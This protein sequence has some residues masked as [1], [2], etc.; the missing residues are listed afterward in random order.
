MKRERVLVIDDDPQLQR[1]LRA[2]LLAR[3]FTVQ[4]AGRGED[5]ILATAEFDPD[6]ILLAL[7]LPGITGVETCRRLREW[8]R[9]PIIALNSGGKDASTVEA[10]DAGADDCVATPFYLAELLARM[11]AIQRRFRDWRGAGRNTSP[12]TFGN[13]VVDLVKRQ[14]HLDG[15]LLHFTPTEYELLHVLVSYAGRIVTH[16]ELLTRVWGPSAA[17]DTQYLHVYISQLRRK[18]EADPDA[19][20]HFRTE[21]GV[22][23]EFLAGDGGDSVAAS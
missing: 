8:T 15:R 17:T 3:E 5:G 1:L 7:S 13:L 16:R 14:V 2:Q 12:L 11:R 19:P 18:L 6:M 22:G 9:T 10:L 21:P 4:V 23:Y 20:R